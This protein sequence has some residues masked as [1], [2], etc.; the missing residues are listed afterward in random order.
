MKQLIYLV[1]SLFLLISCSGKPGNGNKRDVPVITVTIEPLRYFT[2][3]I[4]GDHFN[5]VSMV[6]KGSSPE[7]YDPTPQQLVSLGKSD[8]YLRIG[9]IGFEATWMDKLSANAPGMKIFDT[10]QGVDLI[11]DKGHSH[12]DHYHEGGIDPHIWNSTVN[13]RII[14]R[15]I[16]HALIALDKENETYYTARYDS[17][18][19]EIQLTDSII[20][21]ILSVDADTSFMIYHPALSYFAHEYDL[22]QIPIEKGGKEPSPAYLKEL[23]DLCK[24][25]GVHTIF[26]QPEFD[27]RNA[28]MIA[29][30]TGTKIVRVNPLAYDWQEEMINTAKA[31]KAENR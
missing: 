7:T 22:H 29:E 21:G 12:G 13:A 5:V 31:L 17:L 8:A 4:A 9:H 2:E 16:L 23:I 18:Q 28:E 11:R 24:H 27:V 10:S 6:P 20:R 1:I 19:R 14:T 15:N 26:V 3:A 30:E 25:N